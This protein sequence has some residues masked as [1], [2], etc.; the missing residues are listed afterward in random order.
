MPLFVREV[1]RPRSS[2]LAFP[3]YT[4]L[5]PVR[6]TSL[7][8][9]TPSAFRHYRRSPAAPGPDTVANPPRF[10]ITTGSMVGDKIREIHILGRELW[11]VIFPYPLTV[12][13]N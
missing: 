12:Y 3:A 13:I 8:E 1:P 11:G 7:T 9:D 5:T 4:A 10:L 6:A 2:G